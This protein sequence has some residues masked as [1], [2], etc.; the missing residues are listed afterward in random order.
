MQSAL[1]KVIV[2]VKENLIAVDETP[3]VT[4]PRVPDQDW[5][6]ETKHG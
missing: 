2:T 5:D 6:L 3:T 4:G 1:A